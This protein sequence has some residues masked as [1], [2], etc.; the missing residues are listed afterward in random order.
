MCTNCPHLATCPYSTVFETP[1]IPD[2][3]TVLRKYPNA[4][5]PFVLVP[6]LDQRTALPPGTPL[7]LGI[8]LIGRGIEYLPHFIQVFE[9]MGRDGRYG[10]RFRLRSVVSAVES[11]RLVY[12]G[13]TSRFAA[14]PVL[15][16]PAETS[17]PVG[18]MSLEF[19]TP[20]RIRTEGRYNLRPDF[21]AITQA[22][23]RR[24]HL[25]IAIYGDREASGEMDWVH[26]LL[27]RA[28][29]VKTRRAEFRLY[30]WDRMSGRQGRRV[31]M[32]G[33]IGTLEAEGEL[34]ELAAYFRAGEWVSVGSGTSMGMGRYRM[35]VGG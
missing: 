13:M 29:R 25:L 3:F 1:V 27:R 17:Q 31:Q 8:T 33:V 4:P 2:Q 26:D 23:L 19:L 10:G 22:L 21:V 7:E 9:G 20:L 24:I 34:S 18:R 32:D 12:D 11:E 35:E 15:W 5:H 6:P 16:Q 28:D 30:A 14:E